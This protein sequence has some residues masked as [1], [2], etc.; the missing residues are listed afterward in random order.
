MVG[1]VV[2]VT[3]ASLAARSYVGEE[4]S[5]AL[6]IVGFLGV[7]TL[8]MAGVIA[9]GLKNRPNPGDARPGP[10]VHPPGV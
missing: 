3:V 2:V 5:H 4:L 1:G 9:V 10:D 6:A 8:I 7:I